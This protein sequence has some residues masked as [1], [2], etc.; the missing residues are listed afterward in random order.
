[1]DTMR[2]QE[3]GDL[4]GQDERE[5]LADSSE[6]AAGAPAAVGRDERRMQ[7]RAYNFWASLLGNRTYPAIDDLH[8]ETLGDFGPN[9]VVLDFSEGIDNPLIG[10]LGENIARECDIEGNIRTLADVPSRSLL[11]RITDHYMQILANQAPIGFE[12]EFVNQRGITILYR[13]ILLPFSRDDRTIDH[14]FGV[15]NWKS[16][17]AEV[18]EARRR[19]APSEAKKPGADIPAMLRETAPM[20]GWADGPADVGGFDFIDPNGA[21]LDAAPIDLA[22]YELPAA[23]FS[24]GPGLD[25]GLLDERIVE[26][27]AAA[28]PELGAD[29]LLADWLAL[30][31]HEVQVL[32]GCEDRTRK[33]LYEAIGRA[34]DFALAAEQSPEDLAE[35]IEDAGLV[36]QERAP[37]LPL[38]KLV[39]GADYDKT[40]LT[41]FATAIAHGRRLDLE[42]GRLAALLAE[43]PGGLKAVVRR[44]RD[45]RRADAGDLH[46]HPSSHANLIEALRQL[47]PRPLESASAGSEFTILVARRSADGRLQLLG[48]V[49]DDERLLDRAARHLVG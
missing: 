45:L 2:A 26:G 6:R 34:Y 36:M 9:G 41:E 23:R 48:E 49:A 3:Y 31:H 7:V 25:D 40:R 28:L 44:E 46:A 18:A 11:S 37:L 1:M 47:A 19:A 4:A 24:D 16:E 21:G 20:N 35:L 14:I 39:F 22:P 15:I 5:E 43:T 42:A 32:R 17:S 8:P 27:E 13:G 38:V 29:A 10:F 12:A 33:A 30:A